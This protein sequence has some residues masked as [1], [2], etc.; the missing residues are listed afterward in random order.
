MGKKGAVSIHPISSIKMAVSRTVRLRDHASSG[1][2]AGLVQ[3]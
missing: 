3:V 1:V 2:R